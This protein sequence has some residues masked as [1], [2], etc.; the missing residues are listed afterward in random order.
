VQAPDQHETQPVPQ[1]PSPLT[2]PPAR[3]RDW[4]ADDLE[5]DIGDPNFDLTF[6]DSDRLEED[7]HPQAD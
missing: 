3:T 6:D 5:A 2:T 4:S 1:E 7:A